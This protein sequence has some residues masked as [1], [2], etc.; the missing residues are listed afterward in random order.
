MKPSKR[1]LAKPMERPR[2]KPLPPRID[3]PTPARGSLLTKASLQ[4]K[5]SPAAP[6]VYRP[7]A[8][9][10]VLQTRMRGVS[11][12]VDKAGRGVVPRAAAAAHHLQPKPRTPQTQAKLIKPVAPVGRPVS[13][14]KALQR[15]ESGSLRASS[16]PKAPSVY[17]PQRTPK[18][19]Q[20][21]QAQPTS[22]VKNRG[23]RGPSS[24]SNAGAR[25]IQR[26]IRIAGNNYMGNYAGD[27][28]PENMVPLLNGIGKVITKFF[29]G[30]PVKRGPLALIRA[31]GVYTFETIADLVTYMTTAEGAPPMIMTKEFGAGHGD[32][33][34]NH[35][36][37][38]QK[39][40]W[41]I[42]KQAAITLMEAELDKHMAVLL[43]GT[44]EVGWKSW[45]IGAQADNDI[46]DTVAGSV[47][48]FCM[49][50]QVSK[51]TNTISYHGYP[52]QRLLK[53]GVGAT[54]KSLE[55]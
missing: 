6:P 10:R 54:K 18:V 40:Q 5:K 7:Q 41:S 2:G 47:S 13:S 50:V 45:Y 36:V 52:D 20:R 14:I 35:A 23:A 4:L 17:S 19:L 53:T 51:E 46:G 31:P 26:R 11:Q 42:S 34:F 55:E 21:K 30:E 32:L 49:Q 48:M 8:L 39:A 25:T 43:A 15:K 28:T 12:P 16:Q 9:P 22:E 33:H 29:G 38:A 24:P 1:T 27:Y 3:L 37:T 44:P